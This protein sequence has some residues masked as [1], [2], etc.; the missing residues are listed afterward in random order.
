MLRY[1]SYEW[2][3][4]KAHLA[5]IEP[6]VEV[7]IDDFGD[8]PFVRITALLIDGADMLESRS[9]T[10]RGL[11]EE[12]KSAIYADQNWLDECLYQEGWIY[13]SRGGMDPSAR[14]ARR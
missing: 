4:G 13:I 9:P 5:D 6:D 1:Y 10:V 7:F 14:W 12:I 8:E 2:R 11:G 3:D